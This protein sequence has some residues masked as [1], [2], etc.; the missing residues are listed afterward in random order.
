[1][2]R[3]SVFVAVMV[4]PHSGFGERCLDHSNF[5]PDHKSQL[6]Y[7]VAFLFEKTDY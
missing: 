3:G 6:Q 2:G 4:A 5:S 1:M 7:L